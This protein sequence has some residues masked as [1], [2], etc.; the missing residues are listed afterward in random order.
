MMRV[1]CGAGLWIAQPI[2][3]STPPTSLCAPSRVGPRARF[4]GHHSEESRLKVAPEQRDLGLRFLGDPPLDLPVEGDGPPADDVGE[5]EPVKPRVAEQHR[6]EVCGERAS[7]RLMP[8][9]HPSIRPSVRGSSSS[10][11]STQEY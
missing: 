4:L 5:L 8:S 3:R 11:Q 7:P 6:R 9:V 1:M 10:P 2:A